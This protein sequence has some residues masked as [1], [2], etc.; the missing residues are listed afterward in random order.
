MLEV[1]KW[2]NNDCV[3]CLEC[4]DDKRLVCWSISEAEGTIRPEIVKANVY[5]LIGWFR[6][7][8]GPEIIK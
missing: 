3:L 1:G 2:E 7:A 6:D 8:V 5:W 4:R